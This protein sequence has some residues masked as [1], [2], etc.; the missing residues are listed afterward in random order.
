VH[1]DTTSARPGPG[2]AR[3]SGWSGRSAGVLAGVGDVASV[4]VFAA[5]GRRSHAETGA[6]A[7]TVATAWPFL[8]GTLLARACLPGRRRRPFSLGSGAAFAAGTVVIGMVVRRLLGLGTALS[9]VMVATV[10]LAGLMVGWR[11]LVGAVRGPRRSG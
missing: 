8:A 3:R 11:A 9:F 4:L 2:A 5:I 10:V 6:V 7:G 1:H